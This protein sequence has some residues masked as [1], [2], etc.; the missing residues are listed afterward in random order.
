VERLKL[1]LAV[2]ELKNELRAA[3]YQNKEGLNE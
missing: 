3:T 2:S 1:K